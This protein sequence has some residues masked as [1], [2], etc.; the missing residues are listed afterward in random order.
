MA[1]G[2]AVTDLLTSIAGDAAKSLVEKVV[3]NTKYGPQVV[4]AGASGGAGGAGGT[5]GKGGGPN[6]TA[7]LQPEIL[8]YMKGKSK[9]DVTY[10]PYG[11]PG[12]TQWYWLKF[13]AF[14][15]LGTVGY[16]T[17]KGITRTR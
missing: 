13:V 7:L 16:Y 8:L 5:G 17:Y 1:L 12:P 2:N 10:A 3:I 11:S 4:I 9:P 6:L 14:F 15:A